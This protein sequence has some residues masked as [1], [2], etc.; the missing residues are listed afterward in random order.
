MRT[1]DSIWGISWPYK[2][3]DPRRLCSSE[4]SS[5]HDFYTLF[6]FLAA[7]YLHFLLVLIPVLY[8]LLLVLVTF[9]FPFHQTVLL[10]LAMVTA[11]AGSSLHSYN[12]K[13]QPLCNGLSSAQWDK[14]T[15]WSTHAVK[16]HSY[17]YSPVGRWSEPKFE[18]L[19]NILLTLFR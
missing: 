6:P 4:S 13:V 14:R 19:S 7:F 16:K 9:T 18:F 8:K 1:F 15:Q 11:S 17:T 2:D 3:I 10:A 12:K 5:Y